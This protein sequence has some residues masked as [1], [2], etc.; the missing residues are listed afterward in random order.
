M[1]MGQKQGAEGED[2]ERGGGKSARRR[3]ESAEEEREREGSDSRARGRG[4]GGRSCSFGWGRQRASLPLGQN[5]KCCG[6]LGAEI[7]QGEEPKEKN[8]RKKI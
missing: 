1:K 6:I 8:L 5:G 2:G 3:K 4:V 7:I